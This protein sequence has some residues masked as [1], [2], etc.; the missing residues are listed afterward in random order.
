MDAPTM[1]RFLEDVAKEKP[2]RFTA[3]QLCSFTTNYSKVLGSGGFGVV[4]KG[5]FPNGVKIAVK[6]LKRSLPDKRAEEQF[7]AEDSPEARPPMSAVVKMLEGGVEIMPPPK[8]F[9]YLY[10]S[11]GTNLS[12]GESSYDS[13]SDGTNSYWYKEQTTTIMAKYEIQIASS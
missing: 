4:Y 13:T 12:I 2:V 5:Q 10:S 9:H 8:P 7:M 11:G 1:E 6:V 3:Q